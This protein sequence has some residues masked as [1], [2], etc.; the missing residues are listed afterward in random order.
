MF[1][2]IMFLNSRISWRTSRPALTAAPMIIHA[3]TGGDKKTSEFLS[4]WI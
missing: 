2:I 3:S 1:S 4:N